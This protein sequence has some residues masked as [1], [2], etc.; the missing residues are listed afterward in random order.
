[1]RRGSRVS[2]RATSPD[3]TLPAGEDILLAGQKS[4]AVFGIDPD[5][6]TILWRTQV[7]VRGFLGG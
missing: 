7:G 1:M 3:A 5:I 2:A 6:G 4:G